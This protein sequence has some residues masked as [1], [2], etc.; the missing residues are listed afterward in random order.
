MDLFAERGVDRVTI[1]EVATAADVSPALVMHHYGS[2]QGLKDAVDQRVLDLMEHLIGD[3]AGSLGAA[4]STS[5]AELCAAGLESEPHLVAYLRRVLVEG[6][7]AAGIVFRRLFEVTRATLAAMEQAGLVRPAANPAVR[8]AFLLVND[9]VVFLL[10]DQI[11][12]VI[13]SDPLASDGLAMWSDQV[14]DVYANGIMSE[15][16]TEEGTP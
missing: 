2:K 4:S 15:P 13:G 11:T 6:G 10:R 5:I 8:D 3:V 9:L 1:R 14:I 16:P 12:A 7:D